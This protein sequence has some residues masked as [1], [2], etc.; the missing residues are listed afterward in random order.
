M[1][2][3][4]IETAPRDGTLIDLWV[5]DEHYGA[6]R[7]PDC[8]WGREDYNGFGDPIAEID[9]WV[10]WTKDITGEEY[11]ALIEF[12]FRRG[13]VVRTNEVVTHWLPLPAPPK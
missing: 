12:D 11:W 7:I 4:P 10:Q 9:G 5:I 3:Q 6:S 13:E 1:N 2:W 8:K